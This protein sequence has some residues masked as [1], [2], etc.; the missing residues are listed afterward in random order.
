MYSTGVDGKETIQSKQVS[1]HL[2]PYFTD[3]LKPFF[4]TDLRE[5]RKLLEKL[6]D[7]INSLA[8]EKQKTAFQYAL[9]KS[10]VFHF[11]ESTE[12]LNKSTAIDFR[13]AKKRFAPIGSTIPMGCLATNGKN[14]KEETRKFEHLSDVFFSGNHLDSSQFDEQ[15][16]KSKMP[17][18][19]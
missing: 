14:I 10:K 12:N 19:S 13:K 15:R 18:H 4:S 2:K 8:Y 11:R 6:S 9:W 7:P 17:N 1:K 16:Q 3:E 5:A